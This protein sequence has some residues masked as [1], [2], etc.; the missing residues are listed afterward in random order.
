MFS[1]IKTTNKTEED[2]EDKFLFEDFYG[3]MRLFKCN[4]G[5]TKELNFDSLFDLKKLISDENINTD[6]GMAVLCLILTHCYGNLDSNN[7]FLCKQAGSTIIPTGGLLEKNFLVKILSKTRNMDS[8]L[9]LVYFC[10][11]YLQGNLMKINAGLKTNSWGWWAIELGNIQDIPTEFLYRGKQEL[12]NED[13]V[14]Y[15]F[16]NGKDERFKYNWVIGNEE[17]IINETTSL[18]LKDFKKSISE[19]ESILQNEKNGKNKD[20][21]VLNE[22]KLGLLN[23]HLKYITDNNKLLDIKRNEGI[24]YYFPLKPFDLEYYRILMEDYLKRIT[25]TY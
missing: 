6:C 23:I 2:K 9:K 12:Y 15:A 22:A 13:T 24:E 18:C 3:L 4:Y 16:F 25:G 19:L 10:N 11:N 21:F 17:D 8:D 14:Y 1:F 5:E 7:D 20:S